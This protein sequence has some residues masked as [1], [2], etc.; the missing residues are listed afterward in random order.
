MSP[1]QLNGQADV[2][3]DVYALGVVLH[4][5]ITGDLP[6][7]IP[8]E[9]TRNSR[10]RLTEFLK[11]EIPRVRSRQLNAASPVLE[12]ISD[13][14]RDQLNAVIANALDR[15]KN[16]GELKTVL[17]E[18]I[19]K[20][21]GEGLTKPASIEEFSAKLKNETARQ[22]ARLETGVH[23]AESYVAFDN[24]HAIV[25]RFLD[26]SKT[27]MIMTAE[28]GSGKSALICDITRRLLD[29]KTIMQGVAQQDSSNPI[30]DL[31][32]ESDRLT[33]P[34]PM[35]T[36][37]NIFLPITI[38]GQAFSSPGE[39]TEP[40]VTG[41][42]ANYI[43]QAGIETLGTNSRLVI[44]RCVDW[45]EKQNRHAETPTRLLVI[46]DELHAAGDAE[47]L[48]SQVLRFAES[49]SKSNTVKVLV[50]LKK[51][52]LEIWESRHE[53]TARPLI[54]EKHFRDHLYTLNNSRTTASR[55]PLQI[56]TSKSSNFAL[57][58]AEL[59][60]LS[61]DHAELLFSKIRSDRES[62]AKS[63]SKLPTWG[64]VPDSAKKL[65]KKPLFVKIYW[66]IWDESRRTIFTRNEILAVY[67]NNL[68]Q[69]H[70]NLEAKLNL[71][72]KPLRD[73]P[74]N[75][76]A[77][78]DSTDPS[79]S[80]IMEDL[81]KS[82]LVDASRTRFV[83]DEIFQFIVF[84]NLLQNESPSRLACFESWNEDLLGSFYYY[85]LSRIDDGDWSG[86]FD[87][88]NQNPDTYT[89]TA[90]R[91]L[92]DACIYNKEFVNNLDEFIEFGISTKS[93]S[94][95]QLFQSLSDRFTYA[96]ILLRKFLRAELLIYEML[97]TEIASTDAD[98]LKHAVRLYKAANRLIHDSE[99][100]DA[101]YDVP[102]YLLGCIEII[103]Q[104]RNRNPQIERDFEFIDT[105][106]RAAAL[107]IR[108]VD[109]TQNNRTFSRRLNDSLEKNELDVDDFTEFA[110]NA[111]I[112]LHQH[113]SEYLDD[114]KSIVE[115]PPEQILMFETLL[116]VENA[117][118]S[119]FEQVGDAAI[120]H[121]RAR[122]E[123]NLS[124]DEI[125]KFDSAI[126][127]FLPILITSFDRMPI[128]KFRMLSSLNCQIAELRW[129]NDPNIF[130]N[131]QSAISYISTM[132]VTLS[133][134][135]LQSSELK[136]HDEQINRAIESLRIGTQVS[137][138]FGQDERIFAYIAGLA[139]V[140]ALEAFTRF[141]HD[142]SALKQKLIVL[143]DIF[144]KYANPIFKK[145][146]HSI[147]STHNEVYLSLTKELLAF[148]VGLCEIKDKR[149]LGK[150]LQK[151]QNNLA[152][153]RAKGHVRWYEDDYLASDSM[154]K[155]LK[156]MHKKLKARK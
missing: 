44:D 119:K 151:S 155:K 11:Q 118:L 124:A 77:T 108:I 8:D 56:A 98:I 55:S 3:S 144:H 22:L 110:L 36:A 150:I 43:E 80:K 61:S 114:E 60:T 15:Y 92:F 74:S 129:R 2:R 23:T 78:F 96:P 116:R 136:L 20:I 51:E 31:F 104:L 81:Y 57:P 137:R 149:K 4:E 135:A 28:S 70:P 69:S 59:P 93:K 112:L 35:E 130:T 126:D 63:K 9:S 131:A 26:S 5:L 12:G 14:I 7:S 34:I 89:K 156:K 140:L 76:S 27:V 21:A 72:L 79:L 16:V 19:G 146:L 139:S 45:L 121:C 133:A 134:T 30:D 58:V 152:R 86:F 25:S 88:L 147:P 68:F 32:F 103:H 100:D 17:K 29:E 37:L 101:K 10:K 132:R 65:L 97:R 145:P 83:Y 125:E 138:A 67:T 24:R 102:D 66:D 127:S 13:E 111:E 73:N 105:Y 38:T 18:I 153:I 87:L 117:G 106:F 85:F 62:F 33:P 42:I 99:S 123:Q 6:Y 39:L 49:Y 1:Y 41:R 82:G 142:H 107:F 75:A 122:L 91:V 94:I 40:A 53:S 46:I 148:G 90:E 84:R 109:Y 143:L 141:R 64:D 47:K 113:F 115:L 48:L 50:S 120:H 54:R 154:L 52:V 71:L 128:E 95:E